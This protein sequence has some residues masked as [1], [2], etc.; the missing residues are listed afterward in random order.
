MTSWF[1]QA[2]SHAPQQPAAAA[3]T[4]HA[5]DS[6]LPTF[7]PIVLTAAMLAASSSE[8]PL[9]DLAPVEPLRTGIEHTPLPPQPEV[10]PTSLISSVIGGI[11]PMVDLAPVEPAFSGQEWALAPALAPDGLIPPNAGEHAETPPAPIVPA[12]AGAAE[13]AAALPAAQAPYWPLEW[14]AQV[15]SDDVRLVAVVPH[16]DPRTVTG[17]VT[18]TFSTGVKYRVVARR[19][20]GGSTLRTVREGSAISAIVYR[21]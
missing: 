20:E 17:F 4:T 2:V 14:V 6:S 8:P 3:V 19:V 1:Y 13:F 7:L 5:G 11:P 21:Q 9:V 16:N 10:L 15:A 18:E 12:G